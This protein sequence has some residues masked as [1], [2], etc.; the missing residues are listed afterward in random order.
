VLASLALGVSDPDLRHDAGKLLFAFVATWG[1][2]LW[3]LFLATWY[4]NLP[5]EVA[6][7]LRRWQGAWKGPTAGV[8]AAA[9]AAPFALLFFE[10]LKRSRLTLGLAAALV[11]A[12]LWL[13]RFLLV[14]PSL[15]LPAGPR[16]ALL[17]GGIA[18][19]VGAIFLRA[20]WPHG[21]IVDAPDRASVHVE[22]TAR[23][24]P[25]PDGRRR[26]GT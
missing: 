18:V 7:L 11:L 6:L 19:G 8:L 10:P 13:E 26:S 9:F 24:Q 16:S 23:G 21:P 4:A 3:A 2:L 22:G 12:G 14:V 17:A 25:M 5:E 15:D 20:V 1:Y